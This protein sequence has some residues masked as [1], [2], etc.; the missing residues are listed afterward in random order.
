MINDMISDKLLVK[1]YLYFE[2]GFKIGFAILSFT[3]LF[4]KWNTMGGFTIVSYL[5]CHI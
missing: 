3:A 2:I 5:W 4:E 1:V